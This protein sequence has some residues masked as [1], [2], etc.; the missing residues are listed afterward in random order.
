MGSALWLALLL[1]GLYREVYRE[2][3]VFYWSLS[4][5]VGAGTLAWQL[6]LLPVNAGE[7]I[8]STLPYLVGSFQS[9]LIALA[10]IGLAGRLRGP[11]RTMRFLL[12]MTGAV[13]VAYGVTVAISPEA[14]VLAR[15]LRIE[16][17]VL[18]AGVDLWFGFAFLRFHPL[19]RTAGGLVTILFSV[20]SSVHYSIQA[21]T[22]AGIMRI[23][24]DPYSLIGLTLSALLPMGLAAGMVLMVLRQAR[25]ATRTLQERE[26]QYRVLV[27]ASPDAITMTDLEGR[28]LMVNRRA[29]LLHGLTG[30]EVK[31]RN[32]QDFVA[33]EH[34]G[35]AGDNLTQALEGEVKNV[36]CDL[37][38]K[39]GGVVPCELTAALLRS[40]RG[41]PA[42]LIV[43]TRDISQRKAEAASKAQ[44][45]DQLLQAQKL[46]SVGR[47]A[48]GVAH[49]FNN[50]L[51]VVGGYAALMQMQVQHDPVLLDFVTQI[52]KASERASSLT[53]QLLAFSRKQ[54]IEPRPL[55]V[56]L[57]IDDMSRMIQRIIGD[58]IKLELQLTPHIPRIMADPGQFTQ[59]LMNLA[60]NSRDAMP[61]GGTLRIATEVAV[62]DDAYAAAHLD[63]QPGRYVCVLISDTGIGMDEAT[64]SR[65]FEPFFT[66]KGA[67]KG[68]GLG[69]ATVYGIIK[70][71]GGH[72]LVDSAPGRGATFRMYFPVIESGPEKVTSPPHTL[73]ARANGQGSETILLVEDQPEVRQFAAQVLTS[74]GYRVLAAASG[75]EALELAS[76]HDGSIDLV[77]TDVIMPEMNGRELADK[78]VALR[79]RVKVLFTSGYSES[80]VVH[81]GVLDPGLAYLPKPFT[82][83]ALAG[84]VRSTLG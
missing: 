32:I 72:I 17:Y 26:A 61:E 1:A 35:R 15:N 57:A 62:F 60:V 5:A 84:K 34:R 58:D 7:L 13:W 27:E 50:L 44:L 56:D 12:L 48:G 83:E 39:D 11:Y 25:D 54:V 80:V 69:L 47:L 30:D 55:D 59:V 36:E 73:T 76:T 8:S 3:F 53:N 9:P 77:L 40:A 22:I 16:R 20:A 64:R 78:L 37:L 31:G 70:Q 51:T 46:E 6:A 52:V 66:T 2:Q 75:S 4:L 14:T 38:R 19:A 74:N 68:T 24:P 82:P 18:G 21:V 71:S 29:E 42:G 43:L 49:D 41:R 65:I 23:Y 81:R 79:P 10:A 63:A 45:E 67:G 33:P 28:I